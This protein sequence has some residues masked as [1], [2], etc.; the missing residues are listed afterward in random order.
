MTT[1][2]ANVLGALALALTDRML[3]KVE[4]ELGFGGIAA[5]VLVQIDGGQC[6]TVEALARELRVAQPSITRTV[7]LLHTKRLIQKCP[8]SDRRSFKLRLTPRGRTKVKRVLEQ[9]ADVLEAALERLPQSRR[10]SFAQ[11]L[12]IILENLNQAK[13]SPHRVCRL[14]DFDS[15]GDAEEDC[16]VARSMRLEKQAGSSVQSV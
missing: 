4:D 11:A 8:G 16:P 9:R 13:Q 12:E 14:C 5:G 6:I 7:Q 15:C 1:K 10:A 3:A 2:P